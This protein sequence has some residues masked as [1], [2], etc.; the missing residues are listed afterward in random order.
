MK[1]SRLGHGSCSLG[2]V[3]AALALVAMLQAG[4]DNAQA[5]NGDCGQPVS[6]GGAPLTSDAL[7]VLKTAVA[8]KTCDLCVCDVNNS[9]GISATDA[10][11]D[12]KKAVGQQ[13]DLNC[14]ACVAVSTS[15]TSTS[16]TT[17]AGCPPQDALDNVDLNE[18]YTCIQKFTGQSYFCSE[19][20]E[21]DTI[22]F[23]HQG[24]GN[25]EGRDVPDSGFVYTA[26]LS[27]TTLVW[28]AVSP[29]GYTETGTWEFS[30]D[31]STF[32][33]SSIYIATNNTFQ[34]QCLET[35]AV[36]PATPA[37]PPA[38]PPCL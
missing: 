25:Y 30:S 38:L 18:I 16:T 26:S 17:L 11:V 10:L 34:G 27:C 12:L 3:S 15:T 24:G 7:F 28:S 21:G 4:V 23:T 1:T 35:G 37:D 29:N 20:D 19:Q 36:S 9:G 14:P 8:A 31:L 33:G 32:S 2:L 6:N 13:V 22:R 5:A